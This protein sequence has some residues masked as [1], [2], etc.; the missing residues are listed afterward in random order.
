MNR[1]PPQGGYKLTLLHHAQ[2]HDLRRR[3]GRVGLRINDT[4]ASTTDPDARLCRKSHNAAAIL[5][6]QGHALMENRSGLLVSAVVTH[7]DGQGER[8]AAAAM[9]DALPQSAGRRGVGAD[10]DYDSADFVA[11]CRKRKVS[12]H[13]ACNVNH[14]RYSAIDARTTLHPGFR[15]SQFVCKRI[16]EH[17]GWGRTIG[18]IRQALVR[19]SDVSMDSSNSP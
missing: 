6:F 16:E 3:T 19:G 7:A 9:L 4:R 18:R 5:C 17:F 10:K 2:G 13:V 15:L 14:T 11:A 12:P 8:R 1:W